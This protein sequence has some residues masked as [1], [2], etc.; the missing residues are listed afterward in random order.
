[1]IAELSAATQLET[2][3]THPTGRQAVAITRGR[4]PLRP[5][6]ISPPFRPT[7]IT[8]LGIDLHVRRG[9]SRAAGRSTYRND[10][11]KIAF[12]DCRGQRKVN[13]FEPRLIE[14]DHL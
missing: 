7:L 12:I 3:R 9:G 6:N 8:K 11:W 1:M 13:L 4:R 14:Q 10:Y 2:L 5:W